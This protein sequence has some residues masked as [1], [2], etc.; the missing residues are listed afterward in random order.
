MN[1]TVKRGEIYYADLDPV[2]GSEQGGQRPVVILQNNVGNKFS[3]TTI[4]A[5]ITSQSKKKL[6]TH[7]YLDNINCNL[8]HKSC[9][10]VEQLKTIDKTRLLSFVG[11]LSPNEMKKIEKCLKINFEL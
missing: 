2:Q 6:P 3:P 5:S 10:L 9:V 8:Q 4:V 1:F 11:E 7:V